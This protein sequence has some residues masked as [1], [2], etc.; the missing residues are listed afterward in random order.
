[1]PEL[2]LFVLALTAVA[3]LGLGLARSTN[4]SLSLMRLRRG[5]GV[6]AAVLAVLTFLRGAAAMGAIL[7]LV[8]VALLSGGRWHWRSRSSGLP[9]DGA[10]ATRIVT[11]T[12]E[13]S[14]DHASGTI[15]GRVLRGNF[16]GRSLESL[17]PFE[18]VQLWSDCRF[19]DPKSSQIIEAYL[20]RVH[21]TWRDDMA[22]MGS[23]AG[24]EDATSADNQRM[25]RK[26]ALD[27]LGLEP[28]ASEIEIRRAHRELIL[29]LHPDKGG[30]HTLAAKVNEAKETLV[31]KA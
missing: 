14:L 7:G 24:A 13:A 28:D 25:T 10:V 22:R 21:A 18:L 5:G 26:E 29:K 15:N 2:L 9:S 12:L 3:L 6:F 4:F 19:S 27:I 8:A 11:E 17:T 31:G 16:Q 23:A 30:S 1:M 20:D